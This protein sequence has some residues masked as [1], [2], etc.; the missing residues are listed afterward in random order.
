MF[1]QLAFGITHVVS[2]LSMRFVSLLKETVE[3]V[4]DTWYLLRQFFRYPVGQKLS[5]LPNQQDGGNPLEH[6]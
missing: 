2:K 5:R 1:I 4:L 6:A 3:E